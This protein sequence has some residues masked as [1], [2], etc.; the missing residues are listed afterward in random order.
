MTC[1][2][3]YLDLGSKAITLHS[4]LVPPHELQSD[5]LQT[6]NSGVL[7]SSATPIADIYAQLAVAE[8]ITIAMT[9]VV[10]GRAFSQVKLLRR[11]GFTAN[12]DIH[13]AM[14]DQSQFFRRCGA[15]GLWLSTQERANSAAQTLNSLPEQYQTYG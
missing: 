15:S 3:W 9:S 8:R 12:I 10:D 14:V 7:I 5:E 13:G 2:V 6:W 1:I 11:R 4:E